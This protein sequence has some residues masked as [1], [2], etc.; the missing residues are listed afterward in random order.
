MNPVI[1]CYA[2]ATLLILK[3]MDSAGLGAVARPEVTFTPN[4]GKV[5]TGESIIITCVVE[6]TVENPI[7]FWYKNGNQWKIDKQMF[8]IDYTKIEDTG[9][10]QCRAPTGDVSEIVRLE[11]AYSYLILQVPS[12]VYEGDDVFLRCYSWPGFSLRR[13]LF[14]KDQSAFLP[15]DGGNGLLLS[16]FKKDMAGKYK[17]VKKDEQTAIATYSDET[18]IHVRDLFSDPKLVVTPNPTL[19]GDEMTLVCYTNLSLLRQATKLLFAFYRKGQNVQ[20]FTHFNKYSI[21]SVLIEDSDK[22]SCMVK[23]SPSNVRKESPVLYVQV[24]E[25]FSNPVIETEPNQTIEGDRMTLTCDTSLTKH[26]EITELLFAFYMNGLKVQSFNS[27]NKY[28]IPSIQLEDS[29]NY[30]CEV[31]T[32]RKNVRKKSQEMNIQVQANI[33]YL[34]TGLPQKISRENPK[35]SINSNS[36][37]LLILSLFLMS[38]TRLSAPALD[39]L[40]VENLIVILGTKTT[41]FGF[42]T[43]WGFLGICH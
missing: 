37:T 32:S 6:S 28:L 38:G 42:S 23:T 40:P 1:L 31:K 30:S 39:L 24:H 27:S 34:D 13:T 12:S 29:G 18:F 5:F 26:R 19:E 9:D 16:N 20:F 41:L 43:G 21:R 14:Y 11:V 25:L 8:T 10:Y 2:T 4:W 3:F 17:C 35:L 33:A 15:S 7:I 36:L 22:Y